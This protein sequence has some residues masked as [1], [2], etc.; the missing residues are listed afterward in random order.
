MHKRATYLLIVQNRHSGINGMTR[1]QHHH[2]GVACLGPSGPN[3]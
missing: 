2:A 3:G 1:W